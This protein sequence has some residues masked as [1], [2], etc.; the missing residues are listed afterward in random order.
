VLG[1]A[2]GCAVQVELASALDLGSGPA[3]PDGSGAEKICRSL[4]LRA[5]SEYYGCLLKAGDDEGR[6]SRCGGRFTQEF[7]RADRLSPGCGPLTSLGPT[8]RLA[9]EQAAEMLVSGPLGN[10]GQ[11][12]Q[13]VQDQA[14][15][16]L[17]SSTSGPCSTVLVNTSQK[18]ITCQLTTPGE[19]SSVS[20]VALSQVLSQLASYDVNGSSVTENT[21]LWLQAWGGSGG[22]SHD[23]SHGGPGGFAQTITSIADLANMGIVNLYFYLGNAGSYTGLSGG[24]GGAAS[25]VT[26]QNLTLTP[27]TEPYSSMIILLAGGGGGS[28]G[29]GE[30]LK[31]CLGEAP[32]FGGTGGV[33]ISSLNQGAVGAGSDASEGGKGGNQGVGGAGQGGADSGKDGIGGSGGEDGEGYGDQVPGNPG[34]TNTGTVS[35]T[36][37]SGQGGNGQSDDAVC[38]SG[39]GAGGG[40]W[41]GGGGGGRGNETTKAGAGGGGGSTSIA[42]TQSDGDAPTSMPTNPN[43]SSGF[44]QLVFNLDPDQSQ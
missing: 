40:G 11:T 8:E 18:T 20:V 31:G 33:A 10:L 2:L 3:S 21:V 9:E 30:G 14:S 26:S 4:K 36:F 7:D 27:S 5:V 13:L 12:Q 29:D 19:A 6:Q 24:Q 22:N 16:M 28:G 38:T 23:Y 1:I 39:G 17:G 42:S 37:T 34:W 41:G 43:G 35:L 44:V 32:H 25:I 15:A